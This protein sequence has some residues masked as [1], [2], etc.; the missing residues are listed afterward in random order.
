VNQQ[1]LNNE[2]DRIRDPYFRV[3]YESGMHIV[4]ELN[5][6]GARKN[7]VEVV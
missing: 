1:L 2:R 3:E 4:R 7:Q 6:P 5:A